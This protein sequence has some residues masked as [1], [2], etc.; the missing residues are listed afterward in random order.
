M[1]AL[2]RTRRGNDT[3]VIARDQRRT[4]AALGLLLRSHRRCSS[5]NV[6]RE[7]SGPRAGAPPGAHQASQRLVPL[8]RTRR[9]WCGMSLQHPTGRV[10]GNR[11]RSASGKSTLAR[12]LLGLYAPTQGEV[13]HDDQNLADLDLRAGA[14]AAGHRSTG[15]VHLRPIGPRQHRAVEPVGDPRPSDCRSAT[16]RD[17]RRHLGDADGLPLFSQTGALLCREASV[18]AS[19][20]RGPRSRRRPSVARRGDEFSRPRVREDGDGQPLAQRC[21]RI[22]IAHRLSTI[23]LPMR[24]S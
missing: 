11:R 21:A 5:A 23:A 20:W 14:A 22:I 10:R 2:E 19:P 3:T 4:A 24:S 8:R 15:P 6:S 13:Y 12:L 9:M 16:R 18:N 7:G 17:S 1:L